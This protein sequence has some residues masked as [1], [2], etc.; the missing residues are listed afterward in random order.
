MDVAG[1]IT[2]AVTGIIFLVLPFIAYLIGRA[3]SPPIDY[4]TKLERFE[5]GNIPS[6]RGRGFFLMQYYP[7]LLLFIAMESYVVLI[8]FI[9]LS[10]VVGI[11]VNSLVLIL[12]SSVFILPSFIYALRKAGVIDLWKAD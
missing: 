5:S 10:S 3:V 2:L 8:L 12:L 4:P 7:Y 6:G 11:A 1:I 9:A